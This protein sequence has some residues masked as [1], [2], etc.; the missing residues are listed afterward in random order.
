MEKWKERLAFG[1]LI[2]AFLVPISIL[3]NRIDNEQIGVAFLRWIDN[4]EAFEGRLMQK[5]LSSSDDR[6]PEE[7]ALFGQVEEVAASLVPDFSGLSIPERWRLIHN[8]DFEPLRERF[9]DL[10][11]DAKITLAEGEIEW[12]NPDVSANVGALVLG[13]RKLVA[14]ILWLKVD[15]FWHLGLAQRMLPMMETVVALDPHFIEA[16][17]LGAWHLSYNVTVTVHSAEEK[18]KY[19]EQGIGLLE[20]GI[21]NN[22]RSAKLYT[23]LGFSIYFIKLDD[24]EKS[25]YYMG[26]AIRYE[27]EPWMERAYALALERFGEEEQSLALLEDYASR[28]PGFIAQNRTMGR[29]RK[30]LEARRLEKE[31]KLQEAFKIWEFIKEDDRIDVVAP[32]EAQRLKVLLGNQVG[33]IEAASG[34]SDNS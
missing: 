9:L 6:A 28:H 11:L 7:K 34:A 16:Y 14:D 5:F 21:K 26:E 8:P 2:L 24:W 15:E 22:P 30:K 29:L 32:H 33:S 12:S 19:T 25:A 1:A 3:Q 23:E 20:L 27:H 18:M 17:A 31:G 10:V 13:F 4:Q